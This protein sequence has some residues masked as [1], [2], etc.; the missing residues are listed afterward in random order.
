MNS[1]IP[2]AR[3]R[4]CC[5]PRAAWATAGVVVLDG[6][7]GMRLAAVAIRHAIATTIRALLR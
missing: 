3:S 2:T 5:S 6:L 1:T 7:N 4:S